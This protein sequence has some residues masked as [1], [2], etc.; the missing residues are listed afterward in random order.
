MKY[1]QEPVTVDYFQLQQQQLYY[2]V[3]VLGSVGLRST[4]R[5]HLYK[6]LN[7]GNITQFPL[8]KRRRGERKSETF[9]VYCVCR[10]PECLEKDMVKCSA[11]LQWYHIQGSVPEDALQDLDVHWHCHVCQ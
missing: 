2:M 10:M 5:K 3:I 11:C 1:K 7:E 9:S 8:L 4:I 6:C